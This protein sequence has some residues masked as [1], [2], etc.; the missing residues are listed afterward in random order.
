MEELNMCGPKLK[1]RV[2]WGALL[3]P[4]KGW[5]TP[6]ICTLF[7]PLQLWIHDWGLVLLWNSFVT[8]KTKR[9]FKKATRRHWTECLLWS[10]TFDE[11]WSKRWASFASLQW[12]RWTP[13]RSGLLFLIK[14]GAEAQQAQHKAYAST[15]LRNVAKK[16]CSFTEL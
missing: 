16:T 3:S 4:L 10:L 15:G 7:D 2:W 14:H 6:I 9:P 8:L 5:V 12:A 1:L 13:I 11:S